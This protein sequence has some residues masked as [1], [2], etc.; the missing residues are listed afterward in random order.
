MSQAVDIPTGL[1][2]FWTI[3]NAQAGGSAA[4]V[5]I[6]NAYVAVGAWLTAGYGKYLADLMK[7]VQEN[8]DTLTSMQDALD[9]WSVASWTDT[10]GRTA[11]LADWGIDLRSL[12]S[13]ADY[14]Y[15][16]YTNP[17]GTATTNAN[18]PPV[19][20]SGKLSDLQASFGT[21][22][23]NYALGTVYVSSDGKYFYNFGFSL[24]ELKAPLTG[25]VPATTTPTDSDLTRWKTGIKQAADQRTQSSQTL[26]A[27]MQD[28]MSSY[29][30]YYQFTTDIM[31]RSARD[32][33]GI[34]ANF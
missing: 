3:P 30:K 26:L 12:W 16:G 8:T 24:Q 4:P 13:T 6:Y 20:F 32:K 28:K 29:D 25:Q 21:D 34:T 10:A 31:Q 19:P 18:Y 7:T 33:E 5:D 27:F 15:I 22:Y 9:N 14:G 2:T 11:K 1:S 17:N 23:L